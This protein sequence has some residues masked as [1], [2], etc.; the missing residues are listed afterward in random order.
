[1]GRSYYGDGVGEGDDL[2]GQKD[3][4]DCVGGDVAENYSRNSGVDGERELASWIAEFGSDIVRLVMLVC[5][6]CEASYW[7]T[8]LVPA[9]VCP[10]CTIQRSRVESK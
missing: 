5:T 7:V 6:A 8:D 9:G 3:V 10:K 1:L 2:P 4:V